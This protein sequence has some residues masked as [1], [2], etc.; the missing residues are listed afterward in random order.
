MRM[1][2]RRT[3][4]A[5]SP[6]QPRERDGVAQSR[7]LADAEHRDARRLRLAGQ[8]SALR[9]ATDRVLEARRRQSNDR[10][11]Y[12]ALRAADPETRDHMQNTNAFQIH[13]RLQ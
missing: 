6:N 3:E 9:Q 12:Q 11:D 4:G 8:R 13:P 5:D 7:E 2:D 1:D 10:R